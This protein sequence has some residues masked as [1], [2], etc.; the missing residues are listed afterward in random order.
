MLL[1]CEITFAFGFKFWIQ[2]YKPFCILFV[3]ILE[4]SELFVCEFVFRNISLVKPE[5]SEKI[6][7][8]IGD[9]ITHVKKV[10]NWTDKTG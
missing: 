2:L 7:N 6:V 10:I 8:T 5:I 3:S 1:C 4:W 9:I